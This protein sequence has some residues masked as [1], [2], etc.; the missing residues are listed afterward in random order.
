MLRREASCVHCPCRGELRAVCHGPVCVS[1]LR[2]L[3]N[4]AGRGE[5]LLCV[6]GRERGWSKGSLACHTWLSPLQEGKLS[7]V[8]WGR[9]RG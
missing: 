1:A 6:W 8:G 4:N 5:F 3:G 2:E 9:K 7:C